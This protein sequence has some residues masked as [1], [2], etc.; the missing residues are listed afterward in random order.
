MKRRLNL[1][2]AP[3][4]YQPGEYIPVA[5]ADATHPLTPH[6]DFAIE[7]SLVGWRVSL[8][9]PCAKQAISAT[10]DTNRFADAAALLVPA[11]PDAPM[12]SMGAGDLPVEGFLWRADWK[13]PMKIRAEGFGTVQRLAA[14]QGWTAI[15]VWQHGLWSVRFEFP[16]WPALEQQKSIGVA[17]WQ[18]ASAQRAGLKSVTADWLKVQV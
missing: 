18:G 11:H 1:I 5:Y 15:G 2:A 10:G 4:S 13:A 17:I 16:S 12:M 6:A 3:P 8:M 7:K 14:P 9:W